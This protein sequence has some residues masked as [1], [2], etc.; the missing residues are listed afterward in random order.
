MNISPD[1]FSLLSS[2]TGFHRDILEKVYRICDL[3]IEINKHIY[4]KKMLVLKGG[5]ALNFIYSFFPRL[6]V[7]ID[8]NFIGELDK[9][10]LIDARKFTENKLRDIFRFKKYVVEENSYSLFKAGF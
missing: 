10:R 8:F 2:K 5:T 9:E 4:L 3:L 7:D 6:S 1:Y